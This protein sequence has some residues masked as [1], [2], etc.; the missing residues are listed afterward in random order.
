MAEISA[1]SPE[2][3]KWI[4]GG[5]AADIVVCLLERFVSRALTNRRG[6]SSWMFMRGCC[7][8]A[9]ESSPCVLMSFF[10]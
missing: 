3:Q 10:P 4:D 1:V 5:A 2:G 7:H 9:L 6:F 8:P